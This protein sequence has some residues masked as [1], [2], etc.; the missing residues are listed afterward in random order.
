MAD[1]YEQPTTKEFGEYLESQ[2]AQP[3]ETYKMWRMRR[4][5]LPTRGTSLP[6][7]A[8]PV[9]QTAAAVPT[10][11]Q[12]VEPAT[13]ASRPVAA[14]AVRPTA[15]AAQMA[16]EDER[17]RR[18]VMEAGTEALK[19]GSV[20]GYA[21]RAAAAG[22]EASHTGGTSSLGEVAGRAYK[23]NVEPVQIMFDGSDPAEIEKL[24]K[25]A[26]WQ[27]LLKTKGWQDTYLAG[28]AFKAQLETDIAATSAVLKDIGLVK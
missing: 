14:S 28:D 13:E 25:S 16:P 6:A 12:D 3:G 10:E 15:P 1:R 26:G 8:A 17:R 2:D 23:L 5:G 11:P 20:T 24:A 7:P 4:D 9:S 22:L 27:E 18:A 19:P 21:E